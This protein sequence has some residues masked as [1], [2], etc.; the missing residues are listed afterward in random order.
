MR[1]YPNCA[2]MSRECTIPY[3]IPEANINIK[4]GDVIQISTLAIHKDPEFYP[5]PEKFD[6]NRFKPEEKAKRHPCAYLPFGAGLRNCIGMRLAMM[7]MKIGLSFLLKDIRVI[8]SEKMKLPIEMKAFTA[9]FLP[10]NQIFVNS[11]FVR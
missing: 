9:F 6:P 1:K 3:T 2:I 7:Q 8:P 10:K 11:E 5:E 4:K